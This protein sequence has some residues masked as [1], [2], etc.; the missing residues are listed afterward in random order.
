MKFPSI[1][2][3]ADGAAQIYLHF[4]AGRQFNIERGSCAIRLGVVQ[5]RISFRIENSNRNM[6]DCGIVIFI[7]PVRIHSTV[8]D[9]W[10]AAEMG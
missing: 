1:N 6:G 10:A 9:G 7:A 2:T 3:L 8:L 4:T 5:N